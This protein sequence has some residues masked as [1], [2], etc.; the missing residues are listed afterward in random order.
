MEK[1]KHIIQPTKVE[2][3]KN[4]RFRIAISYPP[5]PDEKGTPCLG[6]NRQ[7][8]WFKNPTYIYPMVPAYAATLLSSQGYD[9]MWD[10]G[11]AEELSQDEWLSRLK[12]FKP[13]LIVFETKT[14]VVKRHWKLINLLK[15]ESLKIENWKLKIVLVGDHVTAMPEESM[16]SS[17]VDVVAT[18]GD[19]DFLVLNIANSYNH[20]EKLEAGIYYRK[21]ENSKS[22][23]RNSKQIRKVLL[24][25]YSIFDIRIFLFII[26]AI[27]NSIISL[28]NCR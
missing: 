1:I 26:L 22:E 6:Q 21:P 5:M 17:Q 8:Q 24:I 7:F 4:R 13:N 27:L 11:I 19:W 10:D 23:I 15:K 25:R 12:K 28:M 20:K 2:R 16:E 18:G 3:E 9:V 14:P